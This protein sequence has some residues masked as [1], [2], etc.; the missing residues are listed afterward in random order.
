M[1]Y[2]STIADK[3]AEHNKINNPLRQ[4]LFYFWS[5][6]SQFDMLYSRNTCTFTHKLYC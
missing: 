1:K 4:Y 2:M 6:R 3:C 5:I